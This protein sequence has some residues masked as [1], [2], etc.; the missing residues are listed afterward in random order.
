MLTIKTILFETDFSFAS[1]AAF[2]L[3]CAL[4]RDHDAKLVIH[5]VVMPTSALAYREMVLR[6][7]LNDNF[8]AIEEKLKAVTPASGNI[9]VEHRLTQGDAAQEIL[10]MVDEVKA[11][12]VVMGTHGR[13]GLGRLMGSV[14]EKVV[15]QAPCPVLTLKAVAPASQECRQAA[16]YQN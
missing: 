2:G 14:A 8:E 5:H 11:D 13:T 3:A 10:R 1:E 9:A 7:E 16:Q 4:A 6:G 15:R 12:L